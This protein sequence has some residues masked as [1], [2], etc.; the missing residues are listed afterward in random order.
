MGTSD[1]IELL[2]DVIESSKSFEFIEDDVL[3][4][5]DYYTNKKSININFTAL[6]EMLCEL[7]IPNEYIDRL[8]LTDEE[9]EGI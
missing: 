3:N 2:Q 6:I 9:V 4:I 5:K 7:D 8:L 1:K